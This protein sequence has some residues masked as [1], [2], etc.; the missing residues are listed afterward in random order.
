MNKFKISFIKESML[1]SSNFVL[2]FVLLSKLLGFFKQI[3]ISYYFGTTIETDLISLSQDFISNINYV[4]TQIIIISFVSI[5][6]HIKQTDSKKIPLFIVASFKLFL[7]F[8][9]FSTLFILIFSNSI[10]RIIA[11]TYPLELLDILSSYLKLFSLSIIPFIVIAYLSG[12]LTA[13]NRHSQRESSTILQNIVVILVLVFFNY[14][15]IKSLILSFFAYLLMLVLYLIFLSRKFLQ[16]QFRFFLIPIYKNR[17]IL[18]LIKMIIP[19]LLSYSML[20]INEQIN[21]IFASGMTTGSVTALGYGAILSNLVTSLLIVF[22]TMAFT[23]ITSQIA[24]SNRIKSSELLFTYTTIILI[25]SVPISVL[26]ILNSYDIVSFAF[27]RGEFNLESLRITSSALMGYGFMYIPFVIKNMLNNFYYGNKSTFFPT[28]ISALGI[29][30][31]VI[32]TILLSPLFG[33]FGI[34]LATSISELI[35]SIL[36]LL[37]IKKNYPYLKI[38]DFF[39]NLIYLSFG[40]LSSIFVVYYLKH[41]LFDFSIFLKLVITTVTTLLVYFLSITP[42]IVILYKKVKLLRNQQI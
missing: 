13:N 26:V 42:L 24:L 29:I 30:I 14:L 20:Q 23:K 39:T 5:Y 3:L 16:L 35:S 19:L 10:A 11:P 22:I 27:F 38:K 9:V 34:T 8:A 17:D 15:G 25:F 2:I 18:S 33:I 12:I 28:I 40:L 21:K 31:N 7:Y 1:F 32:A 37:T 41:L 4:L 6:I 36:L